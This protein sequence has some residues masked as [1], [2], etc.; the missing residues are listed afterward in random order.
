MSPRVRAVGRGRTKKDA[1]GEYNKKAGRAR[2]S[3]RVLSAEAQQLKAKLTLKG[4]FRPEKMVRK[5][6]E[7][8]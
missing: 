3:R 4:K 1:V 2:D 5:K 6:M 8:S 7:N